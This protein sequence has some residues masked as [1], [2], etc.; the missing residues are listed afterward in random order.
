[1][2][3]GCTVDE[4]AGS[5]DDQIPVRLSVSQEATVTRAADGLYT[6]TTGFDGTESVEVFV[7]SS[8]KHATFTVGTP[9]GTHKSELTGTLY[10]PTTGDANL[11]AVYPSTSTESHTVKYDQTTPANYKA[12]DLMYAKTTV[13]Q[14][15]KDD[16]QNLEF[17]HQLVKLKVVIVKA[18]DVSQVTQVMMKNVKRKAT[19]GLTSSALT[20]SDITSAI[21]E[22]GT[23]AN[24]DNILVSSSESSSTSAQTYTYAVVFPAQAWS[25]TDFIE[26][27]ADSKTLA[28]QLTRAANEWTVGAEYTLT[29]NVSA[30][31]LGATVNIDGWTDSNP[32]VTVNPVV[33]TS[34]NTYTVNGVSFKM[35][36]VKGGDYT[37]IGG[38]SVTGTLS[39]YYIGET[40]VTQAL[41]K[42]VM[43]SYHSVQTNDDL[44][45]VQS[46]PYD[47]ISNSGGFLDKLN[48]ALIE[49]IPEG[50]QFQ[51]PT[52]A[53]WE[54]AASGGI[55]TKGY[56]YAGSDTEGEVAWYIVNS[57][58]SVHPVGKKLPNEL[59]IYDMSGN[60]WEWCQ[61]WFNATIE[62][63]QGTDYVNMVA[64]GLQRHVFRGGSF[65]SA[66]NVYDKVANRA[67]DLSQYGG[68][69]AL[70]AIGF[71]LVL[72]SWATTL[73]ELKT[74]MQAGKSC[75]DYI[76]WVITSDGYIFRSTYAALANSKTPIGII[77]YIGDAGTVDSSAGASEYWG[78]AL[79]LNNLNAT[80]EEIKWC[81]QDGKTNDEYEACIESSGTTYNTEMCGISNTALYIAGKSGHTH[82][83]A[84][85][86]AN[87]NTN[88]PRPSGSSDWFIGTQ[89]QMRLITRN[90]AMK[91]GVTSPS[92]NVPYSSY[93]AV[94]DNAGGTGMS[95]GPYWCSSEYLYQ[96]TK[97]WQ[98]DCRPGTDGGYGGINKNT[99]QRNAR[100][101]FAF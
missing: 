84:A 16:E 21:G 81:V 71:R 34:P 88:V 7:N 25:G 43:G 94:I 98:A 80:G 17:G 35:I 48:M 2:L 31:A 30:A 92:A 28:C 96:T 26:V 52:E 79:A 86:L 20:L 76:G 100:A 64:D 12:S 62:T 4:L 73:V 69:D 22:T 63:S 54:Y 42:A 99:A 101:I 14:E 55:Y 24:E 27:T 67:G 97:H 85:A 5:K 50:M 1:M 56:Q 10:Y 40:E 78:L 53:Q 36:P 68:G 60:C 89:S 32:S 59:G 57:G 91:A 87:Y 83:V 15:D 38:T 44:N 19:V 29:I 61:D 9:D 74:R 66:A 58:N 82:H 37:T 90:M 75:I 65:G 95:G 11:Y 6:N 41:W 46:V 45:P 77:A 23:G 72:A 33:N 8:E 49:Q 93:S 3:A 18:A 47:A 70:R 51:L 13:A 39:D